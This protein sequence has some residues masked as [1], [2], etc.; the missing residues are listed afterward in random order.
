MVDDYKARKMT[1]YAAALGGLLAG[2]TAGV[3][4]AAAYGFG[5]DWLT[6]KVLR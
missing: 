1:A 6:R 4:S 3:V 5:V 2:V